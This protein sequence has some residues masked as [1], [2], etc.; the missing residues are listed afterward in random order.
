[1]YMQV[2]VKVIVAQVLK[3]WYWLPLFVMWRNDAIANAILHEYSIASAK[4]SSNVP[5]AAKRAPMLRTDCA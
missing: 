3:N 1:M 5:G 4:R 2:Y